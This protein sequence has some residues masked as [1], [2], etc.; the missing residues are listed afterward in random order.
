MKPNFISLSM[1]GAITSE[2]TKQKKQRK[3]TVQGLV[4]DW[5]TAHCSGL[6]SCSILIF[7][8]YPSLNHEGFHPI[9]W[10]LVL[11]PPLFISF[12]LAVIPSIF[13]FFHFLGCL[14]ST[15]LLLLRQSSNGPASK[16]KMDIPTYSLS[17][18]PHLHCPWGRILNEH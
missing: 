3:A 12:L 14:L 13:F 16:K 8:L 1:K 11:P 9:A 15:S 18:S 17:S 4:V 7:I 5:L 6:C 10:V 2:M